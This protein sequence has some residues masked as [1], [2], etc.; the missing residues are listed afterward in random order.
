MP[1]YT[2]SEDTKLAEKFKTAVF[3]LMESEKYGMDAYDL[4]FDNRRPFWDGQR[5]TI[6][7]DIV[8][9][10]R[11]GDAV[12][13]YDTGEDDD[14]AVIWKRAAEFFDELT[15]LCVKHG[16]GEPKP[17]EYRGEYGYG[18]GHEFVVGHGSFRAE[19]V[20]DSTGRVELDFTELCKKKKKI[21]LTPPSSPSETTYGGMTLDELKADAEK[22]GSTF[23]GVHTL[24]TPLHQ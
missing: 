23:C 4:D 18:F 5:F 7:L 9:A 21:K 6:E 13:E 17:Q 3:E 10:L 16:A 12:G 11:N 8:E 22:H 15:A 1:T 20:G 2:Y 24:G 19:E 14:E